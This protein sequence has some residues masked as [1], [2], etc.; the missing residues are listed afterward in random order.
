M[1]FLVC[2]FTPEI[3]IATI[4]IVYNLDTA[5]VNPQDIRD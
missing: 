5:C 2:T 3:L 4:E 1:D